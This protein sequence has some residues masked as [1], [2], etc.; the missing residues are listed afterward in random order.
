M[1]SSDGNA[2]KD[3]VAPRLSSSELPCFGGTVSKGT[4]GKDE[5][6]A[7]EITRKD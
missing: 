4:R 3:G 1:A 5:L 2:P 7:G 6:T